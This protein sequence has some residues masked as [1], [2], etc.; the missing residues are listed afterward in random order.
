MAFPAI[1][2]GVYGYPVEEAAPVAIESVRTADTRVEEVRFILFDRPTYE[3]F[4]RALE[5]RG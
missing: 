2:T 4:E 5:A 1:S 3:A